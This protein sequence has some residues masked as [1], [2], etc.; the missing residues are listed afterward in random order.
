MVK[1]KSTGRSR[2]TAKVM[3]PGIA[4]PTLAA[5]AFER[6]LK[7]MATNPG[8]A[9]ICLADLNP[10]TTTKTS[11]T[12]SRAASMVEEE[13]RHMRSVDG[14][15]RLARL[16]KVVERPTQ[17]VAL[18][19]ATVYCGN[20]RISHSTNCGITILVSFLSGHADAVRQLSSAFCV[21]RKFP[22]EEKRFA[23]CKTGN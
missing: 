13:M 11:G 2:A 15:G 12:A 23:N 5:A 17:S 1:V 19:L 7:V 4:E 14:S 6:A 21:P 22:V 20:Y 3:A 9:S 8:S 16:P 10:W 18:A